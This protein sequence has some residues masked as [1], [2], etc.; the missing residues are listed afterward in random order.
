MDLFSNPLFYSYMNCRKSQALR[1]LHTKIPISDMLWDTYESTETVFN[2]IIIDGK[3]GWYYPWRI[4]L[5][6]ELLGIKECTRSYN[7]FESALPYIVNTLDNGNEVYIWIRNKYIPHTMLNQTDLEGCHSIAISSFQKDLNAFDVLDYPFEERYNVEILRDGYN[8]AADDKKQVTYFSLENYCMNDAVQSNINT[9]FCSKIIELSDDFLLYDRLFEAIQ[10]TTENKEISQFV[11]AIGVVTLSRLLTSLFLRSNHYA[12]STIYSFFK[13]IKLAEVIKNYLIRLSI[14]SDRSDIFVLKEKCKLIKEIELESLYKL[15]QEIS[16][17]DKL[18][19]TLRPPEKPKNFRIQCTTDTSV[20]LT[21]DIEKDE[22]DFYE[23]IIYVDSELVVITDQNECNIGEFNPD[24]SY[25]I[26]S[27]TR[28]RLNQ[29]SINESCIH[30][31]TAVTK[32]SG[33]LSLH[34]PV[35][36]SSFESCDF[37]FNHVVDGNDLT[38]WSSEYSDDQWIYIDLGMS[39]EISKIK[40]V[41]EG[42][43]AKEYKIQISNDLKS[44]HDVSHVTNGKG[45][46]FELCELNILGRYVRMLG[47][48]RGTLFGY[49]L[50][51][52]SVFN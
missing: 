25:S 34:K 11:Q 3:P 17:G 49:S 33:N 47:I 19:L 27:R 15:K 30:V 41:W 2:E 37:N 5:N 44:W 14:S 20:W 43:Y 50:W 6:N 28:N 8:H 46:I 10:N 4:N 12:E 16:I 23:Y 52:F 45:E 51:E 36:A 38:R 29:I 22:I 24:K 13:M 26:T 7:D 35:I 42:A 31:R 21:W 1:Y 48:K 39:K 9:L 32:T 18:P 40:L